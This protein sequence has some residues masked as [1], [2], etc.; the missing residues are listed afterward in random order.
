MNLY[1]RFKMYLGRSNLQAAASLP[2]SGKEIDCLDFYKT[3][4]L[5]D[6]ACSPSNQVVVELPAF[7]NQDKLTCMINVHVESA[8]NH[9][10]IE[11]RTELDEQLQISSSKI[12]PQKIFIA[13]VILIDNTQGFSLV[14]WSSL[15]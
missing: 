5:H 15:F 4:N 14:M 9:C 10:L 7:S 3:E 8:T 2:D 6:V 13:C 11:I 1:N 12:Y